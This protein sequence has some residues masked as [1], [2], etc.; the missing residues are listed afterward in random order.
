MEGR[1]VE[2]PGRDFLSVF[3]AALGAGGMVPT[4]PA[5]PYS[6][7]GHIDVVF[8]WIQEEYS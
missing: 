2:K 4:A 5:C 8:P 1:G 3:V 7:P 6:P